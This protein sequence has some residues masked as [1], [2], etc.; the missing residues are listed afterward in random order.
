MVSIRARGDVGRKPERSRPIPRLDVNQWSLW[1]AVRAGL[2][3]WKPETWRAVGTL[4][5][6]ASALAARGGTA[7]D[8]VLRAAAMPSGRRNDAAAAVALRHTAREI[9]ADRPGL[10]ELLRAD[11][12]THVATFWEEHVG[13]HLGP[14]AH[15]ESPPSIAVALNMLVSGDPH[16]TSLQYFLANYGP[17]A[18]VA[19]LGCGDG[20]LVNF[21]LSIDPSLRIDAYDVSPASLERT[22]ALIAALDGAAQRCRLTRIDLNVE[23]LPHD[24]YDAVLTTGSM[25]YIENLDFCFGN[26]RRSLKAGGLLWLNDYVGPNRFQWSDTQMRLANELLAMVP[27]RWRLRDRVMRFDAGAMRDLDPSKAVAPQHIPAALEAHF[28]IVQSWPRGGTLL[29]PIFGSGCL[30]SAMA[31]SEEGASVLSAMFRAEHDLIAAGALPSDSWLYVAKARPTVDVLVRTAFE[32]HASPYFRIGRLGIA[33]DLATWA[34][35]NEVDAFNSVIAR[36]YIAP[37]PPNDL[38]HRTSSVSSDAHFAAHGA[39][40]LQALAAS[41]PEPLARFRSLLDFGVGVGRVARLFK[42]Y[43]GGYVGV[44][45]D[46]EMIDWVKRHLPWVDAHRIEPLRRLPFPDGTFDAVVSISVF[47]HMNEQDH[48]FYLEELWRVTVPGARLLLTVCGARVIDRAEQEPW[49]FQMLS[50]PREE[51]VKAREAFD[52]G[53]GFCFVRQE[54]HLTSEAYEYGNTFISTA[55]IWQRWSQYFEIERVVPGAIHDFQDIVVLR[56]AP[57]DAV[58]TRESADLQQQPI[59]SSS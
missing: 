6:A 5:R 24:L 39:T 15:W 45:V 27:A 21:L 51:L 41:S 59:L 13:R 33:G 1:L 7:K 57:R 42:G 50:M 20:I 8:N 47:T 4:A 26:I 31:K 30:D 2:P 56:R 16:V 29:A 55:Y 35:F 49:V 34:H 52:R 37:F 12:A 58:R 36:E 54:G 17:F 18:H 11:E 23:A 28:E 25:H 48:L 44:D 3:L 53:N 22:R 14:F 38:M 10:A 43:S 40:I 19:E 9:A 32:Q 46:Q